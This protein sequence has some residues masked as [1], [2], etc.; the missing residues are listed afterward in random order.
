MP[1]QVSYPGVYIEETPM[2]S[3]TI[4]G[5]STSITA[6]IGPARRGPVNDPIR[7][8]SFGEFE[9]IFGGLFRSSPM[10]YAVQH[11]FLN[12]GGDAVIVRVHNGATVSKLECKTGAGNNPKKVSFR[13]ANE[14]SWGNA[15]RLRVDDDVS[16]ETAQAYGLATTDLF[17]LTVYDGSTGAIEEFRNLTIKESPRKVDQV[18]ESESKLLRVDGS[19]ADLT[20]VPL[21]HLDPKAGQTVWTDDSASSKVLDGSPGKDGQPLTDAQYTG[22]QNAKT[23]LYAFDKVDAFNLMSIPPVSLEKDSLYTAAGKPSGALTAAE[24]Y[25]RTR[26][27]VLLL[28]PPTSWKSKKEA[29]DGFNA[30]GVADE[31]VAIFFPRIIMLDI[32]QA[33]RPTE[34]APCGAVAG[35]FARTDEERGVWKAPAGINATLKGVQGLSVK[36]T[37]GEHGE[38]NALGVNG[39]RTFPTVGSVI[40]GARTSKGANKLASEFKYI[41]VRR[42]TLYI[43]E[44]LYRG[45]QFAVF[46]PNDEPLWSDIRFSITSFMNGLFRQGAFQGRSAKEAYFVKCDGETTTQ[47][48]VNRGTVNII[49]G[50]APVRPAEFVVIKIQQMAEVGVKRSA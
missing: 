9:R 48:D 27:A 21:A 22:D 1:V 50:F 30:L 34:F 47:D 12:G 32:L 43:E 40:Y 4:S 20:K 15:L 10:S 39:L 49:V 17:N 13:A 2:S 37:D 8:H 44:S 35:V 41:P 11:Y 25:C 42:L 23:G 46:E 38:L 33:S 3:R 45:T 16:K 31:N 24:A 6:F 28:D 18:L 36:L 19:I 26:R 5:T 29:V 7:I 14:G